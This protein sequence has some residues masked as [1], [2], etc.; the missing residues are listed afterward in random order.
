MAN[1]Q[2]FIVKNGLTVLSTDISTGTSTGAIISQGGAGIAGD[3]N[4]GG[5]A[6]IG[7]GLVV[8]GV[9]LLKYDDHVIYVSDVGDDTTGDGQRIQSAYGSLQKA[10]SVAVNGDC[11]FIE[12]GTYTETFPLTIPQGVT[13]KGSGLRSTILQPTT[14][15]NTLDAFH[16]NGET[17][18]SDF[19][20]TGFYKPG[21]AF[22]YATGAKITTK[23]AY[24][25]CF[26]VITKGSSPTISD[27]YGFASN[28]A[29]NGVLI[30]G[31][32]LDSASLEPAMLFN[33]ATFIVPNATGLYM[34]NGA[35]SELVNSFFYFADKAIQAEV[36]TTGYGG[37][38]KTKLRVGG[39][40]GTFSAGEI[41]EYYSS[42]GT[43]ITTATIGSVSGEYI[44]INSP[45]WGFKTNSELGTS[46][47]AIFVSGGATATSI[48]LADYH[49]FGAELRS[50]GSAAIFGNTGVTANGT[51][52]DLKLIAFNMSHIGSG[53]DLSDDTSKT[54]QANEVIQINGGHIYYQT[55]DQDGDFRVGD[56]FFV[57]QRTGDVSFGTATVALSELANLTIT[58]GINNTVLLP[59]S[60]ETGNL[61][62]AG[63]SITTTVG[64]L[65]LDPAGT[66]TTINS[67]TRVNGGFTASGVVT[68]LS[69]TPATTNTGALIV[70]GGASIAG[71]LYVNG[72]LVGDNA[73]TSTNLLG[74]SLG[75]MPYQTAAGKTAFIDIGTAGNVLISNGTTAT[76]QVFTG[77][78][79]AV[80]IN[81]STSATSTTTGALT[82]RGGASVGQ[83]LYVGGNT[84]LTGDLYVDGDQFVVSATNLLIADKTLTLA[85][86]ATTAAAANNS[87]IIIGTGTGYVSFLFNG[88]TGNPAWLSKGSLIPSGTANIGASGT[89]WNV[90][91]GNSVYDN[92]N[93]VVS[94]VTPS[95]GLGISIL[96]LQSGGPAAT[97]AV[98]NTGVLSLI[99]GTDTSVSAATGNV[100]VWDIS[101][102]QS[103][104][105]RGS[106]TPYAIQITAN[107]ASNSQSTGSLVITGGMGVS[108]AVNAGNITS[109]GSA[110]WT[111]ATLTNNNQ[112]SNGANYLTSSTLGEY[113]VSAI[114]AGVGIRV[115]QSTGSVTVTNIGVVSI[116]GSGY[117]A[118]SASSGSGVTVYNLGVTNITTGSGISVST[119]TGTVSIS[120]NDTLQSVT[121]RGATTNQAV[122]FTSTNLSVNTNSGQ[123]LL[124]SG[125]IG[126]LAVY[127][128]TVVD[129]GNRVLTSVTPVAGTAISISAVSTS[130]ANTTFTVNNAGVTSAV[131]TTYLGVSNSSGAVTFTN[132]GVQTIT[133]GTDTAVSASTGTI[134]VWNTGT[135]QSI[136]SRGASTPY[137]L[138]LNSLTNATS[139]NTGALQVAGGVGINKDLWV[140]GAVTIVGTLNATTVVGAISTAT[141]LTGGSLGS[142]PYQTAGGVTKFI[143]IGAA[144]NILQAGATTATWVSTGS[145]LVGAAQFAV[146]AT[147]VSGGFVNATTGRFSGIT[148]VTN[149]T[150]SAG[151]NSG[152]LQVAG[153]AGI[154]GSVYAGQLYDSTNRVITAV[155]P[156]AGS[157][158]G[159]SSLNSTGPSASFQITNLGVHAATGTTYLG[160]SQ[161]TGTVTFTNLGVQT[162]TGS[163]YL[164][165]SAATGTILLTN[166]G[167]QTLTAG[168][169]TAVS[170]STGTIIV[171]N[172][173]TLQSVTDR[174]AVTSNTISITNSAQSTSSITGA[175]TVAGGAGFVKDVNVGGNLNVFGKTVFADSVT[176]NG[177]ATFVL[178]TNTV[179]TDNILE[180][181]TPPTGMGTM[182]SY[183]DG[184][185]IG[186]RFHYRNR[187]LN[188]GSS[189]ALVLADDT[190]WLEWYNTSSE[191]T[192]TG[193]INSGTY[194]GFKL[195]SI[196]LVD[197]TVASST[198]TGALV[199][200]GGVGIGGKLY[201]GG[202]MFSNG[203]QVVTAATLGAFGVSQINAG[204][205]IGVSPTTG[206]GTVT[207]TNL[208]VQYISA[209][210]GITVS[211][212]TGSVII[213]SADTLQLVT[214]RGASSS[215]AIQITNNTA[216]TS[217]STGSLVVTGGV[218]VSG[219]LY[220]TGAS[221]FVGT[222]TG[223]ITTASNILG[224]LPGSLVFQQGAGNT[225]FVGLGLAGQILQSNGTAPVFVSTATLRVGY[226]DNA[227]LAT[228]IAGGTAGQVPYQFAAGTTGFVGGF[229]TAGQ[230]FV[231]NGAS[232]P[233]FQ[234]TLTLASTTPATSISSGALQV[235]GG[236]GI[237]GMLWVGGDIS[238]NGS[239]VV[240]AGN[241]GIFG[242]AQIIA[243]PAIGVSPSSG[244][245]T[246]TVTNLGVQ[247][248]TTVTNGG[249]IISA[250]TGT[251]TI[252][253]NDT[254]QLVTARHPSTNQ[255]ISVTN[256]NVSAN[257]STGQALLVSGGIGAL[258]V[259]ATTLYEGSNRVLTSVNP[260]G[261]TAISITGLSN[262][263][264][265]GAFT[266]NNTG[267]TSAVGTTYIGVSSST[268]AVTFTNLGVQSL[269]A[270]TGTAVSASTGQIT[271]SSTDTLQ[272]V[273][274]RWSTT[275]NRVTIANT[276]AAT[277]TTNGALVISGGV[278]VLG[279]IYARNIYT[280]GQIVGGQ[281]STST[282]LAGGTTGALVYQTAP[283]STGFIGIGTG[284]TILWSNGTTATWTASGALLA[285]VAVTATNISGGLAGWIPIQSRNST[286]SFISSGTAGQ[287]L[288]M[289]TNTAT[290]VSTSTLQVSAALYAGTAT[291]ILGGSAGQLHY[292]SASGTTSFVPLGTAGQLLVSNGAAV[293][294]YQ[295]TLTL[296]STVQ[297]TSTSSGALTVA[298]G[299]GVGGNLW[300]GGVL[301]ATVAGSITTATNIAGGT[302]GAIHYQTAA[303]VTN[304]IGIGPNGSLLY[305]NGST[306]SYISTTSLVV[307]TADKATASATLSGGAPGSIPY[308]S[309]AG[310]TNF[311][312]IANIGNILQI[313]ALSTATWVSTASLRVGYA[314]NANLSTNIAGGTLGAIHYQNAAG[315]TQFIGIGAAGTILQSNGTT[316]TWFSTGTL[317]AG[318]AQNLNAGSAGSIPYQVAPGTTNYISISGNAAASAGAKLLQ[319]NGTSATFI[320]TSSL[321]VGGALFANSSTLAAEIAGTVTGAG[322][323]IYQAGT[324]DTRF[325]GT[326]TAGMVL[327]SQPGAPVYQNTLTLASTVQ[328]SST[329]TGAFQVAGGAGIGGNLYV[330]GVLYATV[331]GSINT[332]SSIAGGTSGAI[333]YQT[334][335][336]VTGFL[337]PGTAGWLLASNGTTP[338]YQNTATVLVGDAL[339]AQSVNNL[340]GGAAGSIPIQRSS[341]VTDYIPIGG[342]GY[343]LQSNGTT[344]TW[345]TTGSL[346]AGIAL[347][348]ISI[349]GGAANQIPYQTAVSATTFSSNFTYNGTALSVG[350]AINGAQFVPTNA[351][352]PT[353]LGMYGTAA[354]GLG[355]ATN[356][357]ARLYFDNVGNAG[358]ATT[359]PA[360]TLDVNGTMRVSGI[361]TVSNTT[362][363]SSAITGALQVAGGVGVQGSMY[364]GAAVASTAIGTGALQVTSGG[365]SVNGD[366]WAQK[367]YSNSIDVVANATI[368]ATAFG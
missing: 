209:G 9:D 228:S 257:T 79:G 126:A 24:I 309:A 18:I 362:A 56:A 143:G 358:V 173:S 311:I 286:T 234:N 178:S 29:G 130:G 111:T 229:G 159:I 298:G 236:V 138:T 347:R 106:S 290:W 368:M 151:T 118:L 262:S 50:I 312:G 176:F 193:Y 117:I 282:N 267:V 57:N 58:D 28:D 179:Y 92:G 105:G 3:L 192:A 204:P 161:S 70:A 75:S 206:T 366:I 64:N 148:T 137:T 133:A 168:T 170:A 146:T 89:P 214:A 96:N 21:Y 328:A 243:G 99:A 107:L 127:A 351:T 190:Q 169:D 53:G 44:Y 224:G 247:S 319:S 113:G 15:T 172:T 359:I 32:I 348:A 119:S 295:S 268:G 139:T 102:L 240:T 244:T 198:L 250:A 101:T 35:R 135:L 59:Q 85:S 69:T 241:L 218:G 252:R 352:V 82:V 260:T 65:T 19:T 213:A 238:S 329:N 287:L 145:L 288:Q 149:I 189:A 90:V 306:A 157:A 62:F 275:T 1:K 51:G 196:K 324:N 301:Y 114:T 316:A 237:G 6:T 296:A 108:G 285:G 136:T 46:T 349:A 72:L 356:N 258:S 12:A 230:V 325:L 87:G 211:T 100:T 131:G 210:G 361:S 212:S 47:Q 235:A 270:G 147:N 134:T 181:H 122:A 132:L 55:V 315:Q 80:Y 183:D 205:Y 97:F 350:G 39:T 128:S 221:T 337:V 293:P 327:V 152:A 73:N 54:I 303:G 120:S 91:Y 182:W 331:S 38:G 166:L 357:T 77:T 121:Q 307:G 191:T 41:L 344:A 292:Q 317:L 322:Q 175:L 256:T 279:D 272:S 360:A 294:T 197:A 16:L 259:V 22:K 78:T 339:R 363:A 318:T 60:I 335:P 340:T 123:A 281:T 83:D 233:N 66:V 67:D 199:V 104:T 239:T 88:S 184:K 2:D 129:S 45:A 278:G 177:T 110:V 52:T 323:I 313:G 153:G 98:T 34:T 330:G 264:G 40:V 202:T 249:L 271:I 326:G 208:G 186:F 291:N 227:S 277:T 14:A 336:G 305:S 320:T 31:S 33:E 334:A 163:T 10:L 48:L 220:V 354:T 207:I 63:G 86:T 232:S 160:V 289:G 314:E 251:V 273:T 269:T 116:Q 7:G 276:S 5:T 36:G 353:T 180:L 13:V 84:Y 164:G 321:Y 367:I 304:F 185:D 43:L 274:D 30:D 17:T 248:L 223:V 302:A 263:G 158:I 154:A 355:L 141:N 280:N 364:I 109:N 297:A 225:Q 187:T 308:Q 195:G 343:L 222:I 216:A 188:T 94:S 194:G 162:I 125:G 341:G 174:G 93:R 165:T 124:V 203:S 95:A 201:V 61:L 171:W 254:F 76:W 245:G 283:G 167:V 265:V 226:A 155:N 8:G 246:V 150:A 231:S 115:N 261:G 242:V 200:G 74:G 142:M 338:Y 26:S 23:S 49:Q 25:E 266:I 27:P 365:A 219:G 332:A 346:I 20:V 71:Q 299:V 140:G 215:A 103:V 284:G 11:I 42:T 345:I 144:G 112:L 255:A 4:L 333:H 156:S 37:V 217:A 68:V 253:S 300:V 342:N 81:N 310:A